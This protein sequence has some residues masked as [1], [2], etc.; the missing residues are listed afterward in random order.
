MT[1]TASGQIGSGGQITMKSNEITF[2]ISLMLSSLLSIFA[3]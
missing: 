1:G 2:F 3:Q